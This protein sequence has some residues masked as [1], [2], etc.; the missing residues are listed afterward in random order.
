MRI[1]LAD[2]HPLFREGVKPVLHKLDEGV[3]IVEAIDYP[4]AFEAM[5]TAGE[6]DLALL[7]L[8][9]PGMASIEGIQKFRASFGDTPLIV[10]S[11][12]D[13]TEEI[14][15]VLAAGAMGYISKASAPEVIVSAMRLVLAGGVYAPPDLLAP[16]G[17]AAAEPAP[18]V[19][20]GHRAH[21]LTERQIE[22]LRLVAQGKSNRQIADELHLTEGTV[23]IH[24][25]AI[26]RTLGVSNRIEATLA[27][28]RM[29]LT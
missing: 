25:A 12:A 1:L 14:R 10:L 11:A 19:N 2:D 8:N 5:R 24:A 9:M 20:H 17:S 27:A 6:I 4:S 26:F 23:K 22:V 16:R 21:G 13:R 3:E 15:Q 18:A 7:D 29:G 28:Q